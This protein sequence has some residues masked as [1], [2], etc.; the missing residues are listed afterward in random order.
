MILTWSIQSDKCTTRSPAQKIQYPEWQIANTKDTTPEA[1]SSYKEAQPLFTPTPSPPIDKPEIKK[2]ERDLSHPYRYPKINTRSSQPRL[3]RE[4]EIVLCNY[5][6]MCL[7][8]IKPFEVAASV[9]H[10]KQCSLNTVTDICNARSKSAI[11]MG[12]K[13]HLLLKQWY[14]NRSLRRYCLKEFGGR[15][16]KNLYKGFV[17][18]KVM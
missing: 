11:M 3:R 7:F 8:F 5:D 6:V 4:K 1:L 13:H 17:E 15:S 2:I 18:V 14:R 16:E 10:P 12:W 9:S